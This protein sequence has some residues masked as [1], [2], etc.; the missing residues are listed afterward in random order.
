MAPSPYAPPRA[1]IAAI[2]TVDVRRGEGLPL[3]CLKCGVTH[4]VAVHP[5]TLLVIGRARIATLMVA[6][7][8]GVT[9][10]IVRSPETRMAVF[11]ALAVLAIAV[12]RLV[13]PGVEMP[14]ALCPSCAR[15]WA[16]G[17]R[18]SKIFRAAMLGC[19]AVVTV[20][21]FVESSSV[22]AG[23]FL[24]G[25]FAAALGL[26]LLR[27]RTRIVVV[28]EVKGDVFTLAL[29]HADAVAAISSARA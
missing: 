6:V 17:V 29:V 10:A 16:S 14:V 2:G 22:L 28:K 25:I 24:F 7:A 11:M 27:M 13:Y 12:R 4:D 26:M 9:V 19:S 3:V 18:W 15:R 5:K 21:V 1:P 8:G 23:V 20:F